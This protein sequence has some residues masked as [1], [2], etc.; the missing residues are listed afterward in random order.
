MQVSSARMKRCRPSNGVVSKLACVRRLALLSK[1]KCSTRRSLPGVWELRLLPCCHRLNL[2]LLL[3]PLFRRLWSPR[4][5]PNG[6]QGKVAVVLSAGRSVVEAVPLLLHSPLPLRPRLPL[7][8][9]RCLLLTS[10]RL[11]RQH[12]QQALPL[13]LPPLPGP[14]PAGMALLWML[15]SIVST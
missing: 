10:S 3:R 4:L 9:R 12:L 5:S 6:L 7:L 1:S 15:I 2:C 13:P 11:R 14:L 8:L